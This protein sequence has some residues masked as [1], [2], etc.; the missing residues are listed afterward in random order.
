VANKRRGAGRIVG[1][2]ELAEIFG[3]SLTTVDHWT[4]AGAPHDSSGSG[5][6]F[7]TAEVV[8]W[9]VAQAVEKATEAAPADQTLD[10]ARRRKTQAEAELAEIELAEKRGQVVQIG[11]AAKLVA[12][13][14]TAVRSRLLAIP[15]KLAPQIAVESDRAACHA[16]LSGVINEALNELVGAVGGG[17]APGADDGESGDAEAAADAHGERVGGLLSEAFV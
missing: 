11:E 17:D 6:K 13:E 9:R 5:P 1:R 2:T 14:Y 10:E 16:L 7:N 8:D 12:E 3:V 15:N 4:R